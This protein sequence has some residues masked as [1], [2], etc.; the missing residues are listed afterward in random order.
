MEAPCGRQDKK[1]L[2]DL[3]ALCVLPSLGFLWGAAQ[4]GKSQLNGRGRGPD[5]LDKKDHER[6]ALL[7]IS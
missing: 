7:H 3:D 6:T 2:R 5:R 1:C 4:Q